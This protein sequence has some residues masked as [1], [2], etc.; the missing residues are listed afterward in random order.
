MTKQPDFFFRREA[1]EEKTA[2]EA[3]GFPAMQAEQAAEA[4]SLTKLW[5]NGIEAA[6]ETGAGFGGKN[7]FA[8]M[9]AK[10]ANGLFA[11]LPGRKKRNG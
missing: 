10:R 7:N 2:G 4:G 1:V 9:T 11:V 3:A 6:M 8:G 5:L